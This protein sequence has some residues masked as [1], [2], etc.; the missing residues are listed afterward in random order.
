MADLGLFGAGLLTAFGFFVG[1]LGS[2]MG[3]GGGIFLVP[4]LVLHLGV[5]IHQA[6]AVSLVSIVAT[7]SAVASVNVERGLA[8]MRLGVVLEMTTALGSIAGA[9]VSSALPGG[10]VQRLFALL[11]LPVSAMMFVRGARQRKGAGRAATGSA[12]APVPPGR[13]GGSFYDPSLHADV[14]YAVRRVAPASALSFVAGSLSGLLGLGGGIIQVP[15]MT[16][17]CGMPMK[18]A[19]ATSNFLMGVSAAASAL[20]YLRQ[21][22][23]VWHLAAVIVAGVLLGSFVGIR[24][25]H[26][27][28][29]GRLQ[30]AFSALVLLAALKMLG[31]AR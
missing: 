10:V 27:T 30:M 2:V 9:L 19:A 20:I 13:F 29:S 8:N 6:V 23:I 11:L 26:K 18:A 7:S 5:P 12:R 14:S 17:L 25:L 31:G 3:V 28:E 21:G 1:V 24:L 16:L 22:L 4:L 15:V